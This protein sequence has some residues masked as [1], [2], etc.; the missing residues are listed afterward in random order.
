MKLRYLSILPLALLAGCAGNRD[1]ANYVAAQQAALQTVQAAR[2][3]LVRLEAEPGAAITGLRS[4]EVYMPEQTPIVQQARPSEWAGVIGTGL[5]VLGVVAGIKYN[6]EAAANLAT[7]VGSAANAGYKYIQAPQA[8]QTVGQG[9]L[10]SGIYVTENGG[11][12]GSGT[13]TDTTHTPT[14]VEQAAPVVVEQAPPVI[15]QQPDPIIVQQPAPLVVD[16]VVVTP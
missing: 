15:V 14:V 7:A 16:P 6:G 12:L 2:K 13:K 9:T 1:Y 8:N 11:V 10:G 3:P 4:L 5:Q